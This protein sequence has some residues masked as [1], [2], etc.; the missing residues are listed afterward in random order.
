MQKVQ[1][2]HT[3]WHCCSHGF[4]NFLFYFY[5]SLYTGCIYLE[6]V[7]TCRSRPQSI[8]HIEQIYFFL[9]CHSFS[10]LLG[11]TSALHGIIQGLRYYTQHNEKYMRNTRD[12]FL[13][14]YTVYWRDELLTW[15]WLALYG[16]LSLSSSSQQ[17]SSQQ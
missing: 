8:V 17:L 14:W 6:M 2:F 7:G 5:N 4:M 3:C 9:W 15:I 16:V 1:G 12:H 13:L 10:V 11:S